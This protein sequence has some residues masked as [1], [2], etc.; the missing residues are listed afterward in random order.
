MTQPHP[1][2]GDHR[3]HSWWSAW[4]I[5][6]CPR[7][8]KHGIFTLLL[9]YKVIWL[10][11]PYWEIK[12]QRR[13]E[14]LFWETFYTWYKKNVCDLNQYRSHHNYGGWRSL[15]SYSNKSCLVNLHQW[16]VTAC[17]LEESERDWETAKVGVGIGRKIGFNRGY[18]PC[19][20]GWIKLVSPVRLSWVELVELTC[21][22][23]SKHWVFTLLKSNLAPP[24]L[25][26][27]VSKFCFERH[28]IRDIKK[29][30]RPEPIR[31]D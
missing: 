29:L 25:L 2:W 31:I 4:W 19:I 17:G 14:F 24:S 30:V 26:G 11:P 10:H 12:L 28:F 1:P 27:G 15:A 3:P 21:P 13:L 18:A 23:G 7:G 20:W 6:S 22:R 9:L 16:S 8:S 5:V